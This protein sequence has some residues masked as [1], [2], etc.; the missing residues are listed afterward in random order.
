MDDTIE[1]TIESLGDRGDGIAVIDGERVFVAGALPGERVQV[2]RTSD[3]QRAY[4]L[5]VL[6]S[7]PSRAK[8]PCPHFGV[9]GGCAAQHLAPDAYAAWKR[10]MVVTALERRGFTAPLVGALLR[11]PPGTRRR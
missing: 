2:R 6:E 3:R 11:T 7:S 9:C 5:A 10:G 8:P 4:L 1:A